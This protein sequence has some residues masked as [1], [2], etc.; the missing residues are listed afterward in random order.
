M[1][2]VSVVI[3]SGAAEWFVAGRGGG[4]HDVPRRRVG[5]GSPTLFSRIHDAKQS[6]RKVEWSVGA[7]S[8]FSGFGCDSRFLN[9]PTTPKHFGIFNVKQI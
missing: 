9:V 5:E 2:P 4:R 7:N 8:L 1:N 6:V 3:E